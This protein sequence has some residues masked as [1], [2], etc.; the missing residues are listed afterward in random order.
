MASPDFVPFDT[1]EDVDDAELLDDTPIPGTEVPRWLQLLGP[2]LLLA[3]I[4]SICTALVTSFPP[5]FTVAVLTFIGSMASF[6]AAPLLALTQS[7]RS[8]RR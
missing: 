8:E 4:G 6:L 3:A 2:C 1:S 5:F 7:A